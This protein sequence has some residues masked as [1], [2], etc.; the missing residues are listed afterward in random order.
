MTETYR[1]VGLMSGTSLDGV[2]L[3]D[4]LFQKIEDKWNYDILNSNTYP[5][6]ENW[7]T[8]LT[9]N[10]HLHASDLLLLDAELGIYFGNLINRFFSDHHI[11]EKDIDLI[12]SH[13]HTLFHAPDKGYTCQ[14]G[15]GAHIKTVTGITTICDFRYQ[16][17]AL[18]GQGAP[19]VPIGDDL[20]FSEYNARLNLGG[21]ANISY[22]ENGLSIAFDI[23]PLNFVLND[24]ARQTGKAFDENGNMGRNGRL[25][26]ELLTSLNKISYYLE[27]RQKTL[28]AEWVMKNIE[29]LLSQ[30]ETEIKSKLRTFTEHAAHQISNT[31]Q[32]IEIETILV[33]GGGAYNDFLMERIR[34]LSGKKLTIPEP[35]LIE[36]KEALVFA[37]L[38]VLRLRNEI[39]ILSSATGAA[40]SHSSGIIYN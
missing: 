4:V 32:K 5:Y 38:G 7:L 6:P 11:P 30:P 24:L 23:C 35:Q 34:K 39:N 37:L 31:L 18:G 33:T 15:H 3:V 22:R 28:G 14:I 12:A 36:F 25:D 17:I 16:D 8:R 29:P 1:A 21:F 9:F 13:G 10:P 27:A 40:H 2:D 26:N 19:L 20:L